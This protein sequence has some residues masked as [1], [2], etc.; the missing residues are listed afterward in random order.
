MTRRLTLIDPDPM[1]RQFLATALED[2]YDLT[3]EVEAVPRP[4]RAGRPEVV[5]VATS[6][7]ATPR[8]DG[9]RSLASAGYRVL[10]LA[11]CWTRE[12]L[13]DSLGAGAGGCIVKS[14][15]VDAL[16]AA[17]AAV[18]A[19]HMVISPEL[20]PLYLDQPRAPAGPA[21]GV[22]RANALLEQLTDR[23]LEV[24]RFVS[25]GL[26]THE[27]AKR[28]FVTTAT[29]KSHISHALAKLGVRNRLEAVL[30]MN[31]IGLLEVAD[32]RASAEQSGSRR[33]R[34]EGTEDA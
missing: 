18:A 13:L 22:E 4:R 8:P 29:V 17:V 6:G 16:T 14:A 11:V 32:D 3:F 27:I 2:S 21:R 9:V 34:M 28:L 7:Q 20:L 15:D 12:S 1:S 19:G 24:L 23:E 10:V 5:L 25:A 33:T 26:A 31:E 30:L